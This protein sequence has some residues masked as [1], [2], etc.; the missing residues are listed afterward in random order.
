LKRLASTVRKPAVPSA[1]PTGTS[2]IPVRSAA[3]PESASS[4]TDAEYP[5]RT[6]TSS[7]CSP[8]SEGAT[9]EDNERIPQPEQDR[10]SRF[11]PAGDSRKGKLMETIT[12][13][14]AISKAEHPEEPRQSKI[15][16]RRTFGDQNLLELYAD[17]VAGKVME[18]MRRARAP[19]CQSD[20]L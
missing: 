4:A 12:N 1:K 18:E 14:A 3:P 10:S 11:L 5:T 7:G 19:V 13:R 15:I 6:T 8:L 16:I 17:Y 20:S 9:E 2:T